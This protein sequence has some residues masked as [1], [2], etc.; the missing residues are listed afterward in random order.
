[1]AD[2]EYC[3]ASFDSEDAYLDHLDA[4]HSEELGRIDRRR[5]ES[6]SS[7]EDTGVATGTLALGGILVVLV[8]AVGAFT[9]LQ[10]GGSG[11]SVDAEQ[12]PTGVGSVHFHGTI[13]M[14]VDGQQ[15]DFSQSQYQLQANAFHFEN[16]GGTRWHGHARGV[17]LEYAMGTLDVGVTES[18]VTYQGTTYRDSDPDTSVTVTVDGQSVTPSEYVLEEGDEIRIAVEQS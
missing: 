13:E 11:G 1:M 4:E 3:D 15:V 5:V 6:R 12:Q 9:L 18:S 10:S 8:V 17:T 14:V 2:C 16:G 7:D